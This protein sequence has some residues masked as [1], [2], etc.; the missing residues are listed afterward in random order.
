MPPRAAEWE[1]IMKKVFFLII[2]MMAVLSGAAVSAAP[3]DGIP[4]IVNI[5]QETKGDWLGQYGSAGSV[6]YWGQAA[7]ATGRDPES[8]KHIENL[9]EGV[10]VF[11]ESKGFGYSVVGNPSEDKRALWLPDGSIRKAITSYA[12]D[13]LRFKVTVAERKIVS[14]YMCD[15][16]SNIINRTIEIINRSGKVCD[17][18]TIATNDGVWISVMADEEFTF[19]AVPYGGG[20]TSINL[21]A[22]M[23]DD[24]QPGDITAARAEDLGGRS[25]QVSWENPNGS[26]VNVYRKNKDEMV[27][28]CIASLGKGAASYTDKDLEPGMRYDYMVCEMDGKIPAVGVDARIETEAYAQ[29]RLTVKNGMLHTLDQP[30]DEI[31]VKVAVTDEAGAPVAGRTVAF[32]LEGA[33]TGMFIPSDLGELVTNSYGEAVLTYPCEYAGEFTILCAL[34][35]DDSAKQTGDQQRVELKIL[36]EEWKEPP[37]LLHVSDEISPGEV[38]SVNGQ[39]MTGDVQLALYP[40][41]GAARVEPPKEAVLA[42]IVQKDTTKYGYYISAV[43]PAEL[44]GGVYDLWVKNAYGWSKPIRLNSAR[45][46]FIT[47]NEINGSSQVYVVG[48][49]FDPAHFDAQGTPSVRLNDGQGNIYPAVIAEAT[50]VS[51]KIGVD[52]VPQGKYFVEVNNGDQNNWS[53]LDNGQTMAVVADGPDP[54]GLGVAWAKDFI[55]DVEFNVADYGAKP[56]DSNE[57]TAAIQKAVDACEAAGGGVVKIPAGEYLIAEIKLGHRVVLM[58][59]G[60]ENT[61]LKYVGQK[62]GNVLTANQNAQDNGYVGVANLTLWNDTLEN[63]PG[64]WYHIGHPWGNYVY[65]KFN[66]T[67]SNIF[68]YGCGLENPFESSGNGVYMVAKEKVLVKDNVMSGGSG[69][70]NG[71]YVTYYMNIVGNDFTYATGALHNCAEFSTIVGNHYT[72]KPEYAREMHGISARGNIFVYDNVGEGCG[73]MEHQHNDGE[74][75]MLEP[76]GLVFDYGTT[77][78]ATEDTITI[79]PTNLN[80]MVD[81]KLQLPEYRIQRI[82]IMIASGRGMG[83]TR[84]IVGTEGQSTVLL[85]RPWDIVPDATS[86]W[87]MVTP[88][89]NSTVY[90]NTGGSTGGTLLFYG[91][92]YDCVSLENELDYM[93]GIFSACFFVP[94]AYRLSPNYYIRVEDCVLTNSYSHTQYNKETICTGMGAFAINRGTAVQGYGIEYKNNVTTAYDK[95]ARAYNFTTVQGDGDGSIMPYMMNVIVT[96]NKAEGF[97]VGLELGQGVSGV[98]LRDNDLNNNDRVLE[99]TGADNV[100]DISGRSFGALGTADQLTGGS[101]AEISD[102]A[103]EAY[104]DIS[105][106]QVQTNE[107]AASRGFTD[108][109]EDYWCRDQIND[110]VQQGIVSGKTETTFAPEEP[111]TRAEFIALTVRAAG[112]TPVSY[113]GIY[114]DVAA[115]DWYAEAIQT[116]YTNNLIDTALEQDGGILPNVQITREEM[117]S[118]L[119]RAYM[120]AE[121]SRTYTQETD[122][123]PDF[124]EVSDYA[125]KYVATGYGKGLFTGDENRMFAPKK[126]LTRAEAAATISSY[127]GNAGYIHIMAENFTDQSGVQLDDGFVAS[128]DANDWVRYDGIQF[129]GRIQGVFADVSVTPAWG[130]T[131]YFYLDDM[132]G[133]PFASLDVTSTGDWTTFQT[134]AGTVANGDITGTHTVYLKFSSEGTCNLKAFKFQIQ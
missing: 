69:L 11:S 127:L 120:A 45:A 126:T 6:I 33:N 49:N 64:M 91:N 13:E 5:D 3:A 60:R 19:R 129:D 10:S 43:M 15:F 59:E 23:V 29:T 7:A 65:D 38:F 94:N 109:P 100:V 108:V 118:V 9:P 132:E 113:K 86:E 125:K 84:F 78:K 76:P 36:S 55:W 4:W 46:L 16:S 130:G 34:L 73:T 22:V 88:F 128:C 30:G 105:Q 74:F 57:D 97:Q 99:D 96:G 81:G 37:V 39:G 123:F 85:D 68:I 95:R 17:T 31:A 117:A 92:G 131:I 101:Q 70:V 25:V 98:I 14:F 54:L 32:T 42:E 119:V 1:I 21:Q 44:A 102:S 62:G 18:R 107:R 122:Y 51:L 87:T 75:L 83:Q 79:V 61:R 90:K 26:A 53:R 116:A 111:I 2:A 48:R 12:Y 58:G 52:G 71:A 114:K 24:Y 115:E 40:A 66:R 93:V 110:L 112:L 47:E 50:R 133:E 121:N 80:Y 41:D 106:V 89:M 20:A 77:L 27:Y 63:D 56:G 103:L 8:P 124:G 67:C 82:A 28:T 104:T 35:P 134:Q 72:G